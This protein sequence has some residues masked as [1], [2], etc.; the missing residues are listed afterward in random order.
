MIGV[1]LVADIVETELSGTIN[2]ALAIDQ[3]Q[4]NVSNF[5]CNY[6]DPNSK[7]HPIL[8]ESIEAA[9]IPRDF[10]ELLDL[11]ERFEVSLPWRDNE[12]HRPSLANL[13]VLQ[14]DGL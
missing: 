10:I 8:W 2:D 9:G 13:L 12:V 7:D 5:L 3:I 14:L 4:I 6:R 1:K 11:I